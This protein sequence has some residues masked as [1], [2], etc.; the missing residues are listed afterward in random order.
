MQKQQDVQ[1]YTVVEVWRGMAAGARSFLDLSLAEKYMRR[2]RARRN[3]QDDDVQLFG[4]NLAL[5]PS[6]RRARHA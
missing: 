3:P 1:I 6:R 4:G 2:L 5:A